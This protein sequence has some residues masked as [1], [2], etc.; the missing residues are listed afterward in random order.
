[1]ST[2]TAEK[3]VFERRWLR[4]RVCRHVWYPR[5][6]ELPEK[7]ASRKCRS[8][9]WNAPTVNSGIGVPPDYEGP[10]PLKCCRCRYEWFPREGRE[11]PVCCP[12]CMSPY[13]NT[14]RRL[15]LRKGSQARTRIVVGGKL[16]PRRAARK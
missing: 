6:D 13:W 16:R 15:K 7:C 10:L 1:M 5:T 2:A 14:P 9:R 3:V 8:L 4:C 11:N 12:S